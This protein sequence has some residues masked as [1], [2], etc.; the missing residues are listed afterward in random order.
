MGS[1]T[2]AAAAHPFT[3][4]LH[5]AGEPNAAPRVALSAAPS[6]PTGSLAQP[7]RSGPLDWGVAPVASAPPGYGVSLP[8]CLP[9][10]VSVTVS[11]CVSPAGLSHCVSPSPPRSPPPPPSLQEEHALRR[12]RRRHTTSTPAWAPVC[13]TPPMMARSSRATTPQARGRRTPRPWTRPCARRWR[14]RCSRSTN[15]KARSSWWASS[16]PS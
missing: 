5:R 2:A 9:H 6:W 8:L 10:C 15:S 13:W 4:P 7:T 12:R 14:A 11:H 1:A 16:E 3:P